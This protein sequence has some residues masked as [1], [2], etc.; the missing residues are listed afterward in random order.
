MEEVHLGKV[1][2]HFGH[3]DGTRKGGGEMVEVGLC[4]SPTGGFQGY[5]V[6]LQV[7]T[8]GN[9]QSSPNSC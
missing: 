3:T 1:E 5:S 9:L 2:V 4:I 8:H 7:F 6:M